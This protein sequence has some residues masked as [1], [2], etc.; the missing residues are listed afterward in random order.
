MPSGMSLVLRVMPVMWA[1][2][3]SG[4]L[5]LDLVAALAIYWVVYR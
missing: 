2:G 4:W 3:F 1:L 5:L